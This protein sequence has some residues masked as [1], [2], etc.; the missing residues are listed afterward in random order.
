MLQDMARLLKHPYSADTK[1]SCGGLNITEIPVHS[2]ILAAR[3]HVLAE[4]M[5]PLRKSDGQKNTDTAEDKISDT[6][7]PHVGN[8]ISKENKCFSVRA[9]RYSAPVL[10][11]A[12][13]N[14]FYVKQTR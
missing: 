9:R 12:Q 7:E 11:N 13:N 4:M 2:S 10:Q 14:L 5:S 8:V 6:P 3:S 1:L